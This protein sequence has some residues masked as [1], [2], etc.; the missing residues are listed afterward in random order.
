VLGDPVGG[1]AEQV[2]AQEVALVAEHDQVALLL[3][4]DADD[5][6]GG[7]AG[8]ELDLELVRRSKMRDE[9]G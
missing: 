7:V 3:V 6:L 2:V 1:G 4:G 8:A 5:Q 9:E